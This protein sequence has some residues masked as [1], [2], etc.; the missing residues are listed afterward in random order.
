MR[1]H[2]TAIR[3]LAEPL[4]PTHYAEVHG[5][6]TYPYVLV[7]SSPGRLTTA[8][9]SDALDILDDTLGVTAVALTGEGVLAVQAAVRA[10]LHGATLA[11]PGRFAG[12]RLAGSQPVA[13]D[14]TVTL[15]DGR[16]P[17]YGVDTY[18]IHSVPGGPDGS[19]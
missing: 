10:V 18:R 1:A 8:T 15:T 7:W 3:A 17:A 2:I 12:L 16:H 19:D 4:Y 11:V 6:P 13:V 5:D 9:L 14:H